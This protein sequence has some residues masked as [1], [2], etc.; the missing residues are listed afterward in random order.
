MFLL[1]LLFLTFASAEPK[2]AVGEAGCAI[3]KD[4]ASKKKTTFGL[5]CDVP[6]SPCS[7][8]KIPLAAI[9]FRT[10]RIS[11]EGEKFTWD[12]VH[13]SREAL[14]R[15]QDL[16]SW[17]RESVVW[18]SSVIADRVGRKVVAHELKA[19]NYGNAETGPGTFWIQGPLK[20]SVTQ[21]IEYLSRADDEFLEKALEILPIEKLRLR[22]GE[23]LG[24]TGSCSKGGG[25][26]IGWYVGAA[27]VAGG[28]KVVFAVRFYDDG[29]HRTRGPAGFRARDIA[30]GM[31]EDYL[32]R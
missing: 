17:M 2:F 9:G 13:R 32:L 30:L 16:H 20:I 21:Q 12:H 24:K 23:V 15:D 25:S 11:S 5:T 7:T 31:L 4:L 26:Q 29:T 1:S 18:V 3:I 8:F 28:K 22:A 14:N 27:G 6:L 10:G 19:M